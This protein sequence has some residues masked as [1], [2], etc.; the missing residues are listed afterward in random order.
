MD[1]DTRPHI[2]F[3]FSLLPG[4][5]SCC[6]QID[7]SVIRI[8]KLGHAQSRQHVIPLLRPHTLLVV[9]EF[10]ERV[11]VVTVAVGIGGMENRTGRINVRHG[12]QSATPVGRILGHGQIAVGQVLTAGLRGRLGID[13]VIG[14]HVSG[15]SHTGNKFAS[16]LDTA[17]R[18]IATKV[19]FTVGTISGFASIDLID[20]T[21]S[22]VTQD[23]GFAGAFHAGARVIVFQTHGRVGHGSARWGRCRGGCRSARRRDRR[24]GGRRDRR[25]GGGRFRGCGSA[26]SSSQFAT[27][28]QEF[29]AILVAVSG[30]RAIFGSRGTT[31]GLAT[32]LVA[33]VFVLSQ[34]LVTIR[35]RAATETSAVT[36]SLKFFL[37][38]VVLRHGF[39]AVVSDGNRRRGCQQQKAQENLGGNH[40]LVS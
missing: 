9:Q 32:V 11:W 37:G 35:S 7:T 15:T 24:G 30:G 38:V 22:G 10:I 6:L 29:V 12:G 18:R 31:A 26:S 16:I 4:Y 3:I 13:W 33:L 34:E 17:G 21:R 1:F 19:T 20:S 14:V 40:D 27:L 39:V 25:R 2:W 28:P 8:T 36:L 5:C 23:H